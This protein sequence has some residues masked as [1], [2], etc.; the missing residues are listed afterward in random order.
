MSYNNYLDTLNSFSLARYNKI[1][2]EL[3]DTRKFVVVL[4]ADRF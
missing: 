2:D 4:D 3:D 1:Y